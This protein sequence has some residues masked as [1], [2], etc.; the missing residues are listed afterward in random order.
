MEDKEMNEA[1][2]LFASIGGKA[3]KKKRGKKHFSEIGKKGAAVRWGKVNEESEE[4]DK[5]KE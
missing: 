2:K 1:I 3:L 4:V 5:Q